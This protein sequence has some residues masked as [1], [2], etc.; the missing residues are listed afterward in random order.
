MVPHERLRRI[1]RVRLVLG[2]AMVL[3]LVLGAGCKHRRSALRPV[4]VGPAPAVVAP[5]PCP[6]GDCGGAVLSAPEPAFVEPSEVTP[7]PLNAPAKDQNVVPQSGTEPSLSPATPG[8]E[9]SRAPALTPPSQTSNR[10]TRPAMRTGRSA[11]LR[12]NV[13]A[14]VNDPNDLFTPPRADRPW[15]YIVLHH[16]AHDRGSYAQI[17]REHRERLGTAG[18]GYHFVIGNGTESTDGLI[19]VAQRWSEQKAGAHCRDGKVA[20]LNDYGIGI[21]LIGDLDQSAPT[22]RQLE[23]ARAL[24]AYLQE[25]YDIPARNV[26][27]HAHVAKTATACPGRNLPLEAILDDRGLAAR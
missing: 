14:Y 25:R 5:A 24:V 1:G 27:T 10:T 20:D 12:R 4:F 18:C 6:S 13:Q 26:Q 17:D 15:R 11:L 22:P 23:A 16:S 9:S 7:P 8:I 19:E 2:L 3:S 21:C